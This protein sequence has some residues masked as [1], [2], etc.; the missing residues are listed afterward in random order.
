MI[1]NILKF[2]IVSLNN[3]LAE[4]SV[5]Y[6]MIHIAL[7]IQVVAEGMRLAWTRIQSM[8]FYAELRTA[9]IAIDKKNDS[10]NIPKYIYQT[11]LL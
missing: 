7:P 3:I 8:V 5:W 10:N 11:R 2:R 4:E 1:E 9:A 6:P